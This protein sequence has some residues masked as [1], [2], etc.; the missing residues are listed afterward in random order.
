M[1]GIIGATSPLGIHLVT[2]L[3]Q[4]GH[5]LKAGF[6]NQDKIPQHCQTFTN[7]NWLN[8]DLDAI[9]DWSSEYADCHTIIWLAHC[10][11]CEESDTAI[12][13]NI[14]SWKFFIS[15]LPKKRVR[16]V[17]YISS[18]GSVYGIHEQQPISEEQDRNPIS[19]YGKCKKMM[20]DILLQNQNEAISK[21]IL[22]VGNLYGFYPWLKAKGVVAAFLHSV[23][24]KEPFKYIDEGKAVRDFIH[25]QDVV[26]AIQVAMKVQQPLVV[27]NVGTGIGQTT[28]AVL[29][30]L[31]Q[32]LGAAPKFEICHIPA[33]SIDV[34]QNILSVERITQESSWEPQIVLQIGIR[35]LI[36]EWQQ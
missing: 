17:I 23:K 32:E 4:Q 13:D 30:I 10:R 33:R 3:A 15:E 14:S 5:P 1:I 6:R 21:I 29:D 25:V 8:S 19:T 7:V 20:E 16:R 24:T 34:P 11:Q 9:A 36:Q 35:K 26:R 12:T 18:G 28:A 22:R 27:W 31:K 2:A